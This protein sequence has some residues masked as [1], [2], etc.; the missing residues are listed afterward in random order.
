MEQNQVKQIIEALLFI[1][2][3]P[4]S[5]EM[6]SD[7]LGETGVGHNIEQMVQDI[8]KEYDERQS[9]MELR[10]IAGGYQFSTRKDFAPWIHRLYKEKTTLRLS[11]SA[12][13]TLSIVAYKQPITRS[14]I[15][16][17]RGVEVTG[18]LETLLERK[19]IRIVG[20]KET[21]GRPLLYGTT[22]DFLKHFGLSHLSELPSIGEISAQEESVTETETETETEAPHEENP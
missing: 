4:L 3:T 10:F 15:E 18:V 21:I 1:T 6:I 16:E 12:M 5:V 9:P 17:I 22:M 20:R 8:G 11:Q 13:E 19:L 2:D 14:E 7:V